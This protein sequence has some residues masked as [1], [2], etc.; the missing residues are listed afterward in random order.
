MLASDLPVVGRLV[1]L[2]LNF[3]LMAKCYRAIPSL[4]GHVWLTVAKHT[5]VLPRTI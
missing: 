3:A 4:L 1:L 5:P 2:E